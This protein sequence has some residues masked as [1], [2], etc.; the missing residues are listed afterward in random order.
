MYHKSVVLS[1]GQCMF[2]RKEK[3]RT[4]KVLFFRM[5]YTALTPMISVVLSSM[6]FAYMH[7]KQPRG[8]WD[9]DTP[10]GDVTWLDG[11]PVGLYVIF[12]IV[13]NFDFVLFLNLT[14]VGYCLTVVFMKTRSLW[15]AIGLHAG[16]VTP[17]SLFM[18]IAVR[19][20]DKHSLW[21]G[22]F[23]LSDGYF[24][25]VCLLFIAVYFTQFY[26][27]KKPTGFTL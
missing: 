3:R 25:T 2:Y 20:V 14:L 26:R 4:I 6:F 24:T 5:F 18:D 22:T 17:I 11:F 15:A 21:W 10:P 12:G 1:K 8:L 9:Y 16:W 19:E 27:P 23:R 7:F 13:V